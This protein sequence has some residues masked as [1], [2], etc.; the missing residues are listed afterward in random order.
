MAA[1]A[2]EGTVAAIIKRVAAAAARD[3][4]RI[5]VYSRRRWGMAVRGALSTGHRC[6]R[7]AR[8]RRQPSLGSN[9]G[10]VIP[11]VRRYL[12]SSHFLYYTVVDDSVKDRPNFACS[13][14]PHAPFVVARK[15]DR[16]SV[17]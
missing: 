1:R 15:R 13:H 16:M 11:G 6:Q 5:A 8:F 2:T 17:V 12:F 14:E 9:Y 7:C 10:D 3:I 4:G